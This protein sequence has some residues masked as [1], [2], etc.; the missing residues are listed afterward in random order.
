MKQTWRKSYW[1]W[2]SYVISRTPAKRKNTTLSVWTEEQRTIDVCIT[3]KIQ[4]TVSITVLRRTHQGGKHF[5]FC[6]W[7]NDLT[8]VTAIRWWGVRRAGLIIRTTHLT[9][10]LKAVWFRVLCLDDVARCDIDS[11]ARLCCLLPA[12]FTSRVPLSPLVPCGYNASSTSCVCMHDLRVQVLRN[13]RWS[14][15][16]CSLLLRARW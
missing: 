2:I 13:D 12:N 15:L 16:I 10:K 11:S 5:F 7:L 6:S 1:C 4:K 14:V 8:L 9:E 3:Y